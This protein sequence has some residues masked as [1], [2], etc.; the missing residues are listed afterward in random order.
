M[1]PWTM[2]ILEMPPR[3]SKS[4]LSCHI[5]VLIVLK[6]SLL[7]IISHIAQWHKFSSDILCFAQKMDNHLIFWTNFLQNNS[8]AKWKWRNFESTTE[9]KGDLYPYSTKLK[10]SLSRWKN[11]MGPKMDVARMNVIT[12]FKFSR[13]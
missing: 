10:E 8:L 5:I 2:T 13:K 9:I 4:S 11:L 12:R 1:D 6:P 7:T 3:V